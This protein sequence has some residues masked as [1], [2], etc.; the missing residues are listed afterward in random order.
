MASIKQAARLCLNSLRRWGTSPR[1]YLIAAMAALWIYALVSP[2]LR[3]SQ[4]VDVRVTPWVFPFVLGKWDYVM[5]TMLVVVLLF[6]DAPFINSSTPYECIRAGRK[7]WVL[8]QLA[9]VAVA[10]LLF[11]LFLV[12]LSFLFLLPHVD[13]ANG[14]G[15]VLNTLAQTSAGTEYGGMPISYAVMFKYSP[16]TALVLAALILYLQ[17][18]FVGTAMFA[19]NMIGKRGAGVV[20]GLLLAF[21]PGVADLIGTHSVYYFA[22]TTWANLTVLEMSGTSGRPPLA[23]A[24]GTLAGLIAVSIAVALLVHRK[25]EIEVLMPV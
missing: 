8:A 2:V 16:V 25:K 18:V 6:C 9:Y 3:F 7:R 4:I 5:L 13:L 22:P 1:H 10:S 20:G 24:L 11:V 14:W 17:T 21:M 15:R 12:L 19:L 23:F